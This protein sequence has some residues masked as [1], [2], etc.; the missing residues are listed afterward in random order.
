MGLPS[1]CHAIYVFSSMS[2]SRETRQCDMA[3]LI[4]CRYL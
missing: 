4:W 1:K 2:G 3:R